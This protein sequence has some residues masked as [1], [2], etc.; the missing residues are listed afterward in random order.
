MVPADR[1]RSAGPS[2]LRHVTGPAGTNRVDQPHLWKGYRDRGSNGGTVL[3]WRRS[4]FV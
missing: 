4:G 2:I 1:T 3:G